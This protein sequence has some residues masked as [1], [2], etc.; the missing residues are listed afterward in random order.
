MGGGVGISQPARVRIATE[1]TVYA[2]PETGIGLFP[3]VGGGW[4]LPRLP[5]QSGIW[6]ALTGARLNGA[7]TLSLGIATHFVE[8]GRI[9]ALKAEIVDDAA[10]VFGAPE[11]FA[12]TPGPARIDESRDAIDRLFAFD[13]M[14]EIIAALRAD[15]SDWATRE[16]A[17]L[18]TK[19]PQALKVSLRQ[20]RTGAVLASFA[21]DLAMEYR[22]GG[23]TVRTHD[24]QEGVR[25]VI[26]DK[27]NRPQWS[28]ATL[29]EVTDDM[30]DALFA[31]LPFGEAWTSLI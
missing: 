18:K 12:T 1:R 11:L 17:T 26:L 16:L 23:R 9:A 22:L 10:A 7:E 27:D 3:D 31:P 2:M 5:G 29:E 24:F 21:E 25:A 14:E 20:M 19:S 13:T 30:L 8:S 15:G 6:L 4:Y 28:P